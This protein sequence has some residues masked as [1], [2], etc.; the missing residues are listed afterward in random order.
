MKK[1]IIIAVALLLIAFG[2]YQGTLAIFHQETNVNSPISAGK[3][4]IEIVNSATKKTTDE[5]SF[6]QILPGA[7]VDQPISILNAKEKELYVRIILTRYWIDENGKKVVDANAEYIQPTTMNPSN[8]L[9]SKDDQA[10]NEILYF[11][12]KMPLSASETTSNFIDQ[13]EFSSDIN[14]QRYTKYKA[15]VALDAQAV[16]MIGAQDAMLSQWGIEVEL[17]DN[18]NIVTIT[19]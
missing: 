18:G 8:W 5:T 7:I 15:H 3:L 9:M 19:E 10:N 1:K 16:Q 14:E 17:D 4:G 12:Y 2:A 6:E 11:Y 13:I